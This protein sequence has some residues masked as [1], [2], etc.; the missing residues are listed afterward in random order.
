VKQ[1][2]VSACN[3]LWEIS[4]C[5]TKISNDVTSLLHSTVQYFKPMML[6]VPECNSVLMANQSQCT[7]HVHDLLCKTNNA[8]T[9]IVSSVLISQDLVDLSFIGQLNV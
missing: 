8:T 1:F 5:Q 9:L 3:A 6:F 7:I 4:S 2:P